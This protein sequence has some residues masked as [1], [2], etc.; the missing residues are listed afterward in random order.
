MRRKK[1]R[2]RYTAL[3]PSHPLW[4]H[5]IRSAYVNSDYHAPFV[6]ATAP[7]SIA[8]MTPIRA[9]IFT[10]AH[11]PALPNSLPQTAYCPTLPCSLF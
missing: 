8:A 5:P 3:F 6:V 10:D 11:V 4:F 9:D 2:Y 7:V 1:Q